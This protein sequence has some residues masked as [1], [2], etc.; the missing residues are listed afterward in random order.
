MYFAYLIRKYQPTGSRDGKGVCEIFWVFT[1]A[2]IRGYIHS[3]GSFS[4]E[5]CGFS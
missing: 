5:N 4:E 2:C 1:P 3:V